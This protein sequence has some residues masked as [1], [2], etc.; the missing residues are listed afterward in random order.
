M[1]GAL[2]ILFPG[3]YF[4]NPIVLSAMLSKLDQ[5]VGAVVKALENKRM[6]KNSIVI[7]TSDNGGPAAGFNLNAASNYPLK[8]V[9]NTLWEGLE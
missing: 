7:F 4:K 9:K 5:S 8:G 1:V 6:L 3:T 2:F